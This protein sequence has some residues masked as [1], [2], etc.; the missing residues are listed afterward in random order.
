MQRQRPGYSSGRFFR[1]SCGVWSNV[2]ASRI[3]KIASTST[4]ASNRMKSAPAKTGTIASPHTPNTPMPRGDRR[5]RQQARQ[6]ERKVRHARRETGARQAPSGDRAYDDE[7]ARVNA[8]DRAR[9]AIDAVRRQRKQAEPQR[10]QGQQQRADARREHPRQRPGIARM[11]TFRRR[12]ADRRDQTGKACECD[13]DLRDR[14]QDIADGQQ[15]GRHVACPALPTRVRPRPARRAPSA[16]C[17][18]RLR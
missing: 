7:H 18:P 10:Q 6:R 13:A 5:H 3:R 14:D 2:L 17:A 15:A 1:I 12:R 16:S 8:G 11:P 9:D 4:D